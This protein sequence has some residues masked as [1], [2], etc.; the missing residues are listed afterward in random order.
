M[1]K[2]LTQPSSLVYFDLETTGLNHYHNR[3]IEIAA[4]REQVDQKRKLSSTNSSTPQTYQSF[5]HLGGDRLPHRITELTGITKSTLRTAPPEQHALRKFRDFCGR[6]KE[7][8]YLV[9]HNVE[10]FDKWFLQSRCFRNGLRIPSNWKYLDTIHLAKLL[11]PNL[12]SYSLAAMCRYFQIEQRSAHRADDD[13]RCL[14]LLFHHLA[15][16]YQSQ[17]QI[18][19]PIDSPETLEAM[20]QSTNFKR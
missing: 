4:A 15:R 18:T 8:L 1:R 2:A 3:I 6:T 10:G 14:R 20:W 11:Y 7:P 5:C 17:Y 19:T 13:V 12:S 16:K 9:A